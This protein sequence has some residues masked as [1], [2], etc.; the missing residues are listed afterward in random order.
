MT[1]PNEYINTVGK[2][3]EKFEASLNGSKSTFLHELRKESLAAILKSGL[4]GPKH[5]EYRYTNFGKALEKSI[6]YEGI[7][8]E[9]AAASAPTPLDSFEGYK[10]YF[11]N[12]KLDASRSDLGDLSEKV[13]VTS[14]ASAVKEQGDLKEYLGSIVKSWPDAFSHL[15]TAFA[16]EGVFIR[17]KKNTILDKPLYIIHSNDTSATEVLAHYRNLAIVEEGSQLKVI[18]ANFSTGANTSYTNTVLEIFCKKNASVEWSKL[19]LENETA[20][21]I[22]N[23]LV[24]QE[25]DSKCTINTITLSGQMVRNNLYIALDDENTEAHMYGL[26]LIDGKT[27]VDNHTSVDHRKP[28][29]F[30]NELYKG[31]MDDQS[32]GVFNGK[33]FVRQDA[34]KTNAFQQNNNILLSPNAVINTKPQ[35]EIWADDVKCS[36]GCTT[37]QLDNEQLFY[38]RARGISEDKAR[39]MLL[40]AFAGDVIANISVGPVKE[41]LEQLITDKIEN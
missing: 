21:R 2:A 38:L 15:N 34:Q 6:A 29:S 30:S 8:A 19:Q 23:S 3:F 10:L 11:V 37:G 24:Y 4:P 20:L 32:H 14:L 39:A 5:E 28:N 27:H 13:T 40:H 31:I 12:G 1:T 7:V 9:T 25:R 35:L 41:Y 18:E 33:I 26:Y 17:V 16:K 36:H 22:D